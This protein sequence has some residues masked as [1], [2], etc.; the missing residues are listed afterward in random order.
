M[1]NYK[2]IPVT[3]IV[4]AVSLSMIVSFMANIH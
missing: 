2:C 3:V 1:H 4:P